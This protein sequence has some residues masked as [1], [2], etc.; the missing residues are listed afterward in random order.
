MLR[1]GFIIIFACVRFVQ[2][3]LSDYLAGTFG[4]SKYVSQYVLCSFECAAVN[5]VDCTCRKS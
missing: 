2:E 4:I 3:S 1:V 5:V